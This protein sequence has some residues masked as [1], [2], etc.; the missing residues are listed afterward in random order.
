MLSFYQYKYQKPSQILNTAPL[1][2][3]NPT[4]ASHRS[5]PRNS[6]SGH[7]KKQYKRAVQEQSAISLRTKSQTAELDEEN[8]LTIEEK[9][10]EQNSLTLQ[11]SS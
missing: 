1:N 4:Q 2:D 5:S 3:S 6:D 11:S 9:R 7:T 8:S 10:R